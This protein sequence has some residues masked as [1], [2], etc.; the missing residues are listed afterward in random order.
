MAHGL[1]IGMTESGKTTLA[2][3]LSKEF[4]DKGWAVV[5]YDPFMD[6]GFKCDYRTEDISNLIQVLKKSRRCFVFVDEAGAVC[7][8]HDIETYWLATQSRHWGHNVFFISQ[9][10]IQI[11]KTIREQCRYLMLFSC[12]LSDSKVLANEWNKKELLSANTLKKGE[13]FYCPRF[14]KVRKLNVFE[15]AQKTDI[16]FKR[17]GLSLLSSRRQAAS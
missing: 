14:E 7:G 6:G 15:S 3:Q 13:F 2:K 8:Q 17:N 11:A 4:K 10:G 5:V 9:R 16:D 12:S 1:I